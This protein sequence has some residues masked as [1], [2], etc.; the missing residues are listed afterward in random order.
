MALTRP[1]IAQIYTNVTA[2]NDAIT[3][4][5]AGANQANVDVGLLINRAHG[6]LPN[7]AF[8]YSETL[9]TF[10]TAFTNN[11]GGTDSN[12]VVTNYADITSGNVYTTGLYWT[13]NGQPITLS[14]G[15]SPAAG[16]VGQIQYNDSGT[17][18]AAS[19]IYY[20]GNSAIVANAGIASTSTTTGSFQI[21]GGAGITGNLNVGGNVVGGGVRTT[22]SATPPSNPVAGD[23]WYN[24]TRDTILRYTDDG[25]SK[26]WIDINGPTLIAADVGYGNV[27]VS[28]YLSGNITTGNIAAN[29]YYWA[30]GVAFSSGVS[31]VSSAKSYGMNVLFG[32]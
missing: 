25:V 16:S 15:G 9:D 4:L 10:V 28:A 31:G 14:G 20:S 7:A 13:G 21:I 6:L 19:L 32:S 22:T 11:S 29:G 5:N 12:I 1:K 8:Y 3:V 24:T 27:N 17:L 2:L 26:I 23:I 30:N 18:G